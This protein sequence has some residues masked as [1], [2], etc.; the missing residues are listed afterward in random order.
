[1]YT[2]NAITGLINDSFGPTLS[3]AKA[4]FDKKLKSQAGATFLQSYLDGDIQSRF[5]NLRLNLGYSLKSKHKLSFISTLLN[6]TT[7][8]ESKEDTIEFRGQFGYSLS[9]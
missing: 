3:L 2:N 1:M 4:F 7:F 5:I 6:K 8:G 9:I